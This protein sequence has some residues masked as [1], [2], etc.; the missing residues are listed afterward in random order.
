MKASRNGE[1]SGS[2]R[3]P[4]YPTLGSVSA[5]CASSGT[6]ETRRTS[7][8]ARAPRCIIDLRF[9][10]PDPMEAHRL[11]LFFRRTA[12]DADEA[13]ATLR[14]L[15]CVCRTLAL[16]RRRPPTPAPG[17]RALYGALIE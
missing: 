7:A 12:D 4:R 1:A 6:S 11:V 8:R 15:G 14:S 13:A 10:I 9:P 17:A 2:L 16:S 3:N 5:D